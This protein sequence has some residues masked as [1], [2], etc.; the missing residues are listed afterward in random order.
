MLAINAIFPSHYLIE[1]KNPI[2]SI[3]HCITGINTFNYFT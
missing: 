1:P 2:H 3:T